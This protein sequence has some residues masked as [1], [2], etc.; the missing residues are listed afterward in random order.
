MSS[1]QDVRIFFFLRGWGGGITTLFLATKV[2]TRGTPSSSW[3][4][5]RGESNERHSLGLIINLLHFSPSSVCVSLSGTACTS[6]GCTASVSEWG[7]SLKNLDGSKSPPRNFCA[8][9]HCCSSALVS[10]W[11]SRECPWGPRGSEKSCFFHSRVISS[12]TFPFRFHPS[13]SIFP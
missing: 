2:L 3:R 7:T 11:R 4:T 5:W 6:P 10:A 8:W 9:R 12:W 13:Y 1:Y